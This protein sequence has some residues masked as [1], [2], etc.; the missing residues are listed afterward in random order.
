MLLYIKYRKGSGDIASSRPCPASV[1]TKAFVD[2]NLEEA[3]TAES[4]RVCL[5]LDLQDIEG[6]KDNLSHTN[7]TENREGKK[8]T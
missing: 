5:P 8:K 3:T 2:N 7:D 6:K 1:Q 4:I